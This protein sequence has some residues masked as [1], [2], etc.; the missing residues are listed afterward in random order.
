MFALFDHLSNQ[1]SQ[2][3]E[4]PSQWRSLQDGL[5][6]WLIW[7]QELSLAIWREPLVKWVF[8]ETVT[9]ETTKTADF[10]PDLC[11]HHYLWIQSPLDMGMPVLCWRQNEADMNILVLHY[12]YPHFRKVPLPSITDTPMQ[13]EEQREPSWQTPPLRWQVRQ[14]SGSTADAV[15][16][17]TVIEY[18]TITFGTDRLPILLTALPEH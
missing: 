6:L 8:W 12:G 10:A 15:A 18:I 17:A 2:R 1:A 14:H 7:D 3:Y 13:L 4:V 11:N 9:T 16:L 5:R